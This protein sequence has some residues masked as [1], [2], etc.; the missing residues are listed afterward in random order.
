MWYRTHKFYAKTFVLA[1]HLGNSKLAAIGVRVSKW[2]TYHGLALNVCNDLTPF[3]DIVPCGISDRSVG[4]VKDLLQKRTSYA[5]GKQEIDCDNEL[6]AAVS[7]S[8][9]TTLAKVF[10]L[11]LV[12]RGTQ[13]LDVLGN[14]NNTS[15]E[16][17]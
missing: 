11:N 6:L 13:A 5:E 2:V 17:K 12:D 1:V 14:V 8:L 9:K 4:S 15:A 10:Q 16:L 7:H 3:N